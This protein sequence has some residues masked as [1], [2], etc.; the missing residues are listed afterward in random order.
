MESMELQGRECFGLAA[1]LDGG[2]MASGHQPPS[3]E[4]RQYIHGR[5]VGEGEEYRVA[6]WMQG[7]IGM[8]AGDQLVNCRFGRYADNRHKIPSALLNVRQQAVSFNE[9]FANP[10]Q[11]KQARA[12]L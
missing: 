4:K 9:L 6:V 3:A 12:H 8:E 1:Q 11:R 10:I 5:D 2:A 7:S